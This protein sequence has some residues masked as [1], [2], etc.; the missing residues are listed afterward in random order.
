MNV[1]FNN[2]KTGEV[3]GPD[4]AFNKFCRAK[5]CCA[6]CPLGSFPGTWEDCEAWMWDNIEK[7]AK[8]MEL[9]VVREEEKM[10]PKICE[11]LGVEVGEE[12]KI[13]GLD[14]V[15]FQI[16]DDGTF[17][18][19]PINAPVSSSALLRALDHPEWVE[20]LPHWSPDEV[21]LARAFL[22]ACFSKEDVFFARKSNGRL[23]WGVYS[24]NMDLSENHLPVCL[25]PQIKN[26]QKV[27]LRY[28]VEES[29]GEED[30]I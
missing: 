2:P 4:E 3:M 15:V 9:E 24:E 30:E 11:I 23:C 7:T 6:E 28:I 8:A 14:A 10:K 5:D 13:K 1:K 27:Y 20:R 22:D 19:Q 12:F 17:T 29:E 25:F 21:A 26:D 16:L 18:T